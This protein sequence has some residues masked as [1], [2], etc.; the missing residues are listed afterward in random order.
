MNLEL[1]SG[2]TSYDNS[3]KNRK[4][5]IVTALKVEEMSIENSLSKDNGSSGGDVDTNK[6]PAE[7]NFSMNIPESSY[8]SPIEIPCEELGHGINRY[9]Y[10]VC[11]NLIDANWV[12]LPPATPHQINVSRRMMKYLTGNLDAEISSYPIFP[13]TERNYLRALIARISAGTHVAPKNFYKL[14]ASSGDDDEVEE[15]DEFEDEDICS[16]FSREK[17]N[18]LFTFVRHIKKEGTLS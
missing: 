3:E 13:G 7:W 5:S 16:K 6:Y 12:E 8:H 10:F 17:E 11:H 4:S 2:A 18:F 15:E 1:S 14:G 9:V